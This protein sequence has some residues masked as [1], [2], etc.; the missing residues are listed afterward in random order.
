MNRLFPDLDEANITIVADNARTHRSAFEI[1]SSRR[2]T[3]FAQTAD[4]STTP[5]IPLATATTRRPNVNRWESSPSAQPRNTRACRWESSPSPSQETRKRKDTRLKTP[6]RCRADDSDSESSGC[7]SEDIRSLSQ[8]KPSPIHKSHSW[9]GSA[10]C[11]ARNVTRASFPMIK[12]TGTGTIFNR[13]LETLRMTSY[14]DTLT[15]RSGIPNYK[16]PETVKRAASLQD[17][18]DEPR[19]RTNEILR[20]VLKDMNELG[21]LTNI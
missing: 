8:S 9:P 6:R 13:K 18:F 15:K 16:R 20:S 12:T 1:D 21:G 19:Q 4:V 17:W 2:N 11:T 3:G 7:H 14:Q 5:R 10:R